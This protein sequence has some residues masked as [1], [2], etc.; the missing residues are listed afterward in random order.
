MIKS[1]YSLGWVILNTTD[2][3]LAEKILHPFLPKP[4]PSP[5]FHSVPSIT[6][7]PP[8]CLNQDWKHCPCFLP[9]PLPYSTNQSSNSVNCPILTS[10]VTYLA[11]VTTFVTAFNQTTWP[12]TQTIAIGSQASCYLH[13]QYVLQTGVRILLLKCASCFSL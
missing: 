7:H 6:T 10:L 3:T 1:M 11:L 2:W 9:H 8:N 4:A 12:F 5:T 13:A